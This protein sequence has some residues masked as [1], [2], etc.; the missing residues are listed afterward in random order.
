MKELSTVLDF[1]TKTINIDGIILSMRN[2]NLL[3]GT[4]ILCTLK[5]NNSLAMELKSTQDATK[6]VNQILDTK[7]NNAVIQSIVKVNC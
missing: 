1:K 3:Q 6:H 4:S 7:Y 2:I 5:L